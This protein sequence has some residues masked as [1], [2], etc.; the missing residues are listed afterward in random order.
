MVDTERFQAWT[1][2]GTPGT[3][4]VGPV[5]GSVRYA[6]SS[7]D[8]QATELQGFWIKPL[9]EDAARGE[10]TM[11]M[12]IDPGAYAPKHAHPGE[13]E[14]VYVLEGAFHDRDVTLRPGDYCC[15]A[16]DAPH[17][18][19]SIDGAIVLLIYTRY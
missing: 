1:I 12:K 7:A 6:S 8:W 13:F 19:G 10:K 14:Q 5:T 2:A 4:I 16:P 17:E 11:L 15:R 3:G 9:F 18:A